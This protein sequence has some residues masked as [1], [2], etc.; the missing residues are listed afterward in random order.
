MASQLLEWYFSSDYPRGGRFEMPSI[1][2]QDV[3]LDDLALIRFSSIVRAETKDLDATVHFFEPD[4]RFDEVWKNPEPYLQEIG[5]YRQV[6]TPD[7][8]MFMGMP[9]PLQF[10]NTFRSRWCGWF[11]QE[12]GMTVIPTVSWSTVS[13]YEYCFDGLPTSGVVAVSTVG[14]RDAEESFMA[15][16]SH[17]FRRLSPS[18]VI[19]YGEPFDAMAGMAELVVVPYTRDTRVAERRL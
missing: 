4:D 14:V 3:D 2:R 19:C 15:G 6:L 10:V 9:V 17:M 7:F 5:Q 16:Y 18:V 8:S 12:H 1:K 13:S 11:W